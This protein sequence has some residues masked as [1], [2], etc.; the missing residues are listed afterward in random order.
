MRKTTIELVLLEP[1]QVLDE[2]QKE[3]LAAIITANVEVEGRGGQPVYVRCPY[4]GHIAR[5]D[6]SFLNSDSN[7][8]PKNWII[9]PYC[10]LGSTP[11]I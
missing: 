10:G 5:V 1:A 9:C 11:S 6:L 2:S 7:W 4:C 3:K 8:D